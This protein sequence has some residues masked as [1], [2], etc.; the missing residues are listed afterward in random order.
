MIKTHKIALRPNCDQIAFFYQQCGY[1][2]LVSYN[3][4]LFD[5]R[6]ELSSDTFLSKNKLAHRF[7]QKKKAVDW[8]HA[9]DQRAAKYAIDNLGFSPVQR[10]VAVADIRKTT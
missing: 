2:K 4:A 9:Q 1:A 3:Q 6:T 8:T 5:F 10:P 7:N